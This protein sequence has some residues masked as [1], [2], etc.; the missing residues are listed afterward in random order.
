MEWGIMTERQALQAI[1]N[2]ISFP[3][4]NEIANRLTASVE[5]CSDSE[6]ARVALRREANA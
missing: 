2:K 1:L 3:I 4:A 5:T 6:D